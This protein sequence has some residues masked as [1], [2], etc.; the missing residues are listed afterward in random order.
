[1][2][3]LFSGFQPLSLGEWKK[4]IEKSLKG[5]TFDQLSVNDDNGILIHPVYNSENAKKTS[6]PLFYHHDWNVCTELNVVNEK[7]LN[8]VA[9]SEL[10]G[11]ADALN[12]VIGKETEPKSLLN[13]ILVEHI[14]TNFTFNSSPLTFISEFEKLLEERKLSGDQ[15]NGF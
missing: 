3:N 4:N 11:G 10:G 13:E 15:L 2:E 5:K 6:T 12:F 7:E 1:M 8:A 14:R 9:I